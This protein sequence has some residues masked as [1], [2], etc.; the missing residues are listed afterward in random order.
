MDKIPFSRKAKI[1]HDFYFE[2]RNDE[3]WKD[4]FDQYDL[5]IPVAT[6]FVMGGIAMEQ[7]GFD[8]IEE[9]WVAL[10][11]A[12]NGDPDAVYIDLDDLMYENNA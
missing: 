10:C 3:D 2:Y 5:G 4:F 9:T 7:R 12:A 8:W 11:D 1:I 6:A